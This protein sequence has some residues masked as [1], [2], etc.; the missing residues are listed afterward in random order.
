[1][2]LEILYLHQHFT[3]PDGAGGTRS[4]ALGR[5]L[6]T[7]GHRVTIACGMAEDADAGL[8][9]AFAYGR[10]EGQVGPLRVV[11][12]AIAYAN[13]MGL[14][15]RS[16]AF[17]RFAARATP[18]AVGGGFDTIIA[19][20]TPPTVALPALAALRLRGVPFVFEIRDPWPE[21]LLAM[22]AIRPGLASRALSAL[23]GVACRAAASVVALS[24]GAAESARAHGATSVAVIPN[25]CD[26]DL[27]S[28]QVTRWRP[29]AAAPWEALF[30]YAGAHGKANGLD[31]LL[32][33]AAILK[34][35]GEHRVRLLLVGEGAER[36]R[37]IAQASERHLT[38]VTFLDAMPKRS[39]AALLAGAQGGLLCLAPVPEF[40][41]GTSPN[42]L[43]DLLAAGLPVV[44][45]V[46]GRA[47]R[48]LREGG[49]GI[50]APDPAAMADAM[51]S[52]A[53]APA[54]R[55]A[56]G[57]AARA[58]AV[59]RFD[60]N[61]LAAMFCDLVEGAARPRRDMAVAA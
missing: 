18:L 4:W 6:A 59:H 52:L 40:A 26:L 22:K 43:M 10:R 53:A 45:N 42:K 39:L 19:S 23:S 12:F 20:S 31:Q 7:R 60:R 28:P 58:L 27:F 2:S 46:P 48:W 32:D 11:Q 1:M 44:S 49:A 5:A 3:T 33:A 16:A 30:V 9:G 50:T 21:L 13:A 29:E 54:R 55:A 41:E 15:A 34:A 8:D 57:R 14:A 17:L 47:A 56:M 35:R 24:D 51:A 37:L 38:N 36:R 61:R 25:G